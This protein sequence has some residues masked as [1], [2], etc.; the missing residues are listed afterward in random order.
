VPVF[1]QPGY[2]VGVQ[3]LVWRSNIPVKTIAA[4]SREKHKPRKP[5]DWPVVQ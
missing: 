5:R 4:N 1:R 3:R 2:P